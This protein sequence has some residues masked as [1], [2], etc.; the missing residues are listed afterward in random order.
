MR[1]PF[2]G[3]RYM[4]A[5][6]YVP[7][8]FTFSDIR[9][10][11]AS[12]LTGMNAVLPALGKSTIAVGDDNPL[13]LQLNDFDLGG[14]P[15]RRSESMEEMARCGPIDNF[16]HFPMLYVDLIYAIEGEIVGMPVYFKFDNDIFLSASLLLSRYG[17]CVP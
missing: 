17:I 4:S 10:V 13:I 5:Y 11:S 1:L 7:T 16:S 12:Q 14:A 3:I 9:G 8:G 6:L 15:W 2:K